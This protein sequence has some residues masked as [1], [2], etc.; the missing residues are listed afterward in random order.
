MTR[1]WRAAAK[2][3]ALVAA[4]GTAV[5]LLRA[6]IDN[7]STGWPKTALLLRGALDC[8]ALAPDDDARRTIEALRL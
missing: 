5:T 1:Q 7:P 2:A 6:A 4:P 8:M 3:G